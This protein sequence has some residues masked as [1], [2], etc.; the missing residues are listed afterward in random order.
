MNLALAIALL[1]GGEHVDRTNGYKFVVPDG[2]SVRDEGAPS[3]SLHALTAYSGDERFTIYVLDNPTGL[4]LDQTRD[5]LEPKLKSLPDFKSGKAT[6]GKRE[7]PAFWFTYERE[8]ILRCCAVRGD[9][10]YLVDCVGDCQALRDSFELFDRA[11]GEIEF[12]QGWDAAAKRAKAEGKPILAVLEKYGGLGI[13][14]KLYHMTTFL[15][16]DFVELVRER[17]VAAE[18]TYSQVP[19]PNYFHGG[20]FGVSYMFFTADGKLL[21]DESTRNPVALYAVACDVLAR[22]G[23]PTGKDAETCL[24]RGELAKAEELLRDS[25]DYRLKS[26]LLRRQARYEEALVTLRRL[27]SVPPMDEARLLLDLQ[28]FGDAKKILEGLTTSE[29]RYRLAEVK[30]RTGDRDGARPAF[31]AVAKGDDRWATA[32]QR[33]LE[34]WEV[35]GWG[36]RRW[37][38]E[39]L[40]DLLD[41]PAREKVDADRARRDAVDWLLAH[42]RK[43]GAWLAPFDLDGSDAT[44]PLACD[45]ICGRSLLPYRDRAEV[46]KAIADALGRVLDTHRSVLYAGDRPTLMT[47]EVWAEAFVLRFLA[48]CLR[49]KV[50]DRAKV[51]AAAETIVEDLRKRQRPVGGWTYFLRADAKNPSE[52]ADVAMSFVTAAV[53]T[54]LVEAR[55]AGVKVPDAMIAKGAKCLASME[56]EGGFV[57]MT[58][59]RDAGPEAAGRGPGCARALT[60]VK[61]DAEVRAA[62]EA[63]VANRKTILGEMGKSGMHAGPHGQGCHYVWFDYMLAA[64]AAADV[65]DAK[66]IEAIR[67]DV[68]GT[69]C[70]DGG[71][72]VDF[73]TMGRAYATAAA[74][75]ALERL[76]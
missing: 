26:L 56:R 12:V 27:S 24:R 4:T 25:K 53:L 74:L 10:I 57:Y 40:R 44:F 1:F 61:R 68:L 2:W 38:L 43:N 17:F 11:K 62:L 23:G 5:A 22:L 52:P 9:R 45:A 55:D 31:E 34:N 69:R 33:I 29:A 66:L 71:F 35:I 50:G 32:A 13:G 42:R 3:G 14:S 20:Y 21:R 6:L 28:R 15:D 59:G 46:A 18:L 49:L 63:F 60:L 76:K 67:E 39:D 37:D 8:S 75:L 72:A 7:V 47:Y 51:S 70:A 65:K 30:L 54:G 58:G 36:R 73:P 41:R 19:I 64:D 16:P 48:E